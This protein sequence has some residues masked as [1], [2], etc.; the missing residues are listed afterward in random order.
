MRGSLVSRIGCRAPTTRT[1]G[2]RVKVTAL[3]GGVGGAKLAIGLARALPAEDLT[4]VVNTGDDA[5]VYGVHVSPDVDIVTYWLAGVADVDRG[6]GIKDDTFTLVGWLR[7]L[8]LEAWFSLGDR[9][10]ATCLVR[11]S[12]LRDGATLSEAT[13]EV[14]RR[15]GVAIKVIPMSDDPVR[16]SF[17]TADGRTLEFQEYFVKERHEP[18]VAEVMLNGIDDAKPAPGV[19]DAIAS[20]DTVVVCPSNPVVS[21]GPIVALAGVRD[22]LRDHPH[23]VAVSPIVRGAALKGPADRLL[24][25]VGVEVSAA[26]VAGLYSDFVDVFVFDRVDEHHRDEIESA[27]VT[28]VPLDTIMDNANASEQLARGI[29]SL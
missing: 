3:A 26:G 9:D 8:D 10:Y 24:A 27:G 25:T 29:L 19:M 12:R 6:W 23:V 15:L 4:I 16:T 7:K 14:R 2:A 18:E 17:V 1:G 28:A 13:D 11:T 20:A 5:V 22:A 21:I